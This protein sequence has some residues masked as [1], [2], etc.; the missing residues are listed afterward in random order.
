MASKF[1]RADWAGQAGWSRPLS[2]WQA[3]GL[4]DGETV[5]AI[6]EWEEAQEARSDGSR[7]V[8]ALSYLGVSIAMAAAIM[9]IA[10]ADD[11]GDVWLAV[12]FIEGVIALTFAH[13]AWRAGLRALSDGFAASGVALI[14]VGFG[15]VLDEV[16]GTGQE[17]I[18]FLLICLCVAL[19]GGFVVWQYRSRLTILL[20]AVA[21]ALLPL[22]IAV[23]GDAFEVGIYGS[24]SRDL[25]DWVL[26]T[27]FVLLVLLGF[28]L[29]YATAWLG[30]F[31]DAEAKPL[32][33]LGASLG[34]AWALL[35][36]AGASTDPVI[37]WM[38]LL[39]GW[40]MTALALRQQR[41]ELLPASAVLLLG[42]LAGGLSELD[43]GAGLGL[44]IV[45]LLTVL[46]LTTL[47]IGGP[48]LLGQLGEHWLT[49]LWQAALLAGGVVAA[50]V[51]AS[52]HEAL[53]SIGIIWSLILVFT[54]V[55]LRQRL[56]LAFG[57]IGVYAAGLTLVLGQFESGI[58]AVFGTLAFGLVLV[59]GAI[60][61]RRRELARTDH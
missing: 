7:V 25:A 6:H 24:S 43:S 41:V 59:L 61:W 31:I 58:G 10:L 53:S 49:P 35:G 3:A 32:A 16:G 55:I 56:P 52:D 47:G 42:S 17:S 30:R 12:P 9:F 1:R 57:V 37:D 54:G 26:W 38:L 39:A 34:S 4:L 14:T 60:W 18:G 40:V 50:A 22:T 20:T 19:V 21:F 44:T 36:L 15:F 48:R 28:A 23:E 2:R 46:Q 33:R 29:Q 11:G 27:T 8:D 45:Q 5:A 13:F 51:L